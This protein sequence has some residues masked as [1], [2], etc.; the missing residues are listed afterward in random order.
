MQKSSTCAAGRKDIFTSSLILHK[1][2]P[3]GFRTTAAIYSPCKYQISWF[4]LLFCNSNFFSCNFS[5]TWNI[6][7]PFSSWTFYRWLP[8]HPYAGDIQ[9]I[10]SSTLYCRWLKKS[11]TG[12][13]WYKQGKSRRWWEVEQSKNGGSMWALTTP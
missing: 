2:I 1:R 5:G 12:Q 4:P 10:D 13:K 11:I 3:L 8:E 6:S 9:N 7:D